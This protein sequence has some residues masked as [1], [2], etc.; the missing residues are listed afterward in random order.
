MYY[1]VT[2]TAYDQLIVNSYSTVTN[3]QEQDLSNIKNKIGMPTLATFIQH[4]AEVQA[5]KK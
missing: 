5:N 3:D 4:S 1:S 2:K